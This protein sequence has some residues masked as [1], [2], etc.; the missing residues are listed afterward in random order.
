MTPK[1]H[2][3]GYDYSIYFDLLVVVVWLCCGMVACSLW[4]AFQKRSLRF[5]V[6]VWGGF[7]LLLLLGTLSVSSLIHA[8]RFT[9]RDRC[10]KLV[11][12]YADM[13]GRC[14]HWKIQPG[15]PE[16]FS[17]WSKPFFLPLNQQ[18]SPLPKTE[19]VRRDEQIP[20]KFAIPKCLTA[21]WQDFQPVSD[22]PTHVQRRN[23][24]AVAA[25]TQ[26]SQAFHRS[27]TQ[28]FVQWDSVP[29]A[30]TYRLQWGYFDS[31]KTEW[32]TVYT[33]AK[34]SCVLTV[35]ERKPNFVLTP[36]KG[37]QAP[38][39]IHTFP[40][41][42]VLALRV[43][44]EDG[45]PEDD[46]DFN[47]IIEGLDFPTATNIYIGYTYTMRFVDEHQ[48]QFIAAPISD[49]NKNGF[50]DANEVPNDIGELFPATPLTQYIR[51]HKERAMY[52]D[53]FEDKWGKW[54]VI[55]EPIWTP[56]GKMD[57]FVA[58]DFR[59]DAVNWSMFLERI[60]PICLLVLVMLVYF[61]AVL[62]IN[63]LQI[64]AE[65]ISRLAVQLQHTVVELTEAKQAAEK[66]LQAKTLFLTNMNHEFRTPLNAVLGFTEILIQSSFQCVAE[67]QGLC[68]E[69]IKQ[70]KD[71]GKSLLELVD[72]L[73]GVA[74]MDGSQTPR[75]IVEPVHLRN[76]IQGVV[77]LMRSRAEYKSLTLTVEKPQG[78][79]K[80]ITSDAAHIRQVLVLLVDNAI[81]FTQKG[82]VSIDY[83]IWEQSPDTPSFYVSVSDTGIG[84]D[85]E[86]MHSIFKPFSQSDP[87][88]TRQYGGA[89]IGLAVA[90]QT[91]ELLN[92][93]ISVE[94]HLGEG[95]TFT[96]VFPGQISEPPLEHS[97]PLPKK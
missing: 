71:N 70:I 14:E 9:W 63:R 31:E 29:E 90:R 8:Q 73:L 67:R 13:L 57:G 92:G 36:V 75:L 51:E 44:A 16:R 62:F 83:G 33:G 38:P 47:M 58:M 20:G 32:F 50:I 39:H 7:L 52:F 94:S 5:H 6:S 43:R 46:P 19:N 34:T 88:L 45:T 3:L 60:Y 2:L 87:T 81:K 77:D 10:A 12:S 85:P 48:L 69:A 1:A 49:G 24:W 61:G 26:D 65:A 41:D 84:I 25:L 23:Q 42:A 11:A 80:W 37:V 64:R 82:S 4:L 59:V 15:N 91:A 66:A 54:F 86:R 40:A 89:G 53:V 18:N 72:N 97:L 74:A 78:V 35:P 55:A 93:S 21:D 96:F 79:P 22:V 30:T 56:D 76:L 28:I 17:D 95:S 27:T 68:V